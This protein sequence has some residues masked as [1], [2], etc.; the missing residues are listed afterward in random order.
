MMRSRT[1]P[2][3]LLDFDLL[4]FSRPF[5]LRI[6][7][8]Y[9][10]RHQRLGSDRPSEFQRPHLMYHLNGS[11]FD[12]LGRTSHSVLQLTIPFNFQVK[13]FFPSN[14]RFGA[15]GANFNVRIW[16]RYTNFFISFRYITFDFQKPRSHS[17]GTIFPAVFRTNFTYISPS[18]TIHL[19]T[20]LWQIFLLF[21]YGRVDVQTRLGL[22]LGIDGDTD[23]FN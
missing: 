19:S 15:S 13:K 5:I 7:S 17:C 1:R 11:S 4:H 22:R 2:K 12:V 21:P 3:S 23:L 18:A 14:T 20:P 9:L 16:F 10:H 6:V 8:S